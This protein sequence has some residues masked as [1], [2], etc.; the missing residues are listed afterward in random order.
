MYS[1]FHGNPTADRLEWR[2]IVYSS[3]PLAVIYRLS[4]FFYCIAGGLCMLYAERLRRYDNGFWWCG[5]GSLLVVQGVI[6]YMSDVVSW[7]RHHSVWR[8]IDP[9]M[10]SMLFV[11]FGPGICTRAALGLFV[12]PAS[13]LS[14]W[15]IG[16]V[17]ALFCKSMGAQAS[18]RATCCVDE[19]MLWHTGWHLLPLVAAFCILDLAF[20]LTSA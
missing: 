13:T 9:I 2:P 14:I 4:A 6:A 15:S 12:L 11:A 18:H 5:L 8:S 7:G 20:G 16:C 17:L 3:K 1:P 19:M 10:A